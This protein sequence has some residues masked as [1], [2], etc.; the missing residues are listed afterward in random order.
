MF[1]VGSALLNPFKGYYM[2]CMKLVNFYNNK[3]KFPDTSWCGSYQ[4]I[5]I[6][7]TFSSFI[8]FDGFYYYPL[9]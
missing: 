3:H 7:S 9:W 4:K 2:I 1:A 8:N 6:L 5:G